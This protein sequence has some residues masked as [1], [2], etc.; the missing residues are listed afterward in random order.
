MKNTYVQCTTKYTA[1]RV[2]GSRGEGFGGLTCDDTSGRQPT[3][4][5]HTTHARLSPL[6]YSS[7]VECA[8]R[9]R[10]HEVLERVVR[11]GLV[12]ELQ[13]RHSRHRAAA[14]QRERLRGRARVRRV[15]RHI[16]PTCRRLTSEV[17]FYST[18]FFWQLLASYS[19]FEQFR[20]RQ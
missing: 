4:H 15:T 6:S 10:R 11:V 3:V 9:E 19:S 18:F 2:R 14:S 17:R 13:P 7:L 1:A 16:T 8:L 12:Q 5:T 20:P